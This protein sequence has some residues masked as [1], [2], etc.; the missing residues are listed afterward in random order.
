M[1]R[2]AAYSLPGVPLIHAGEPATGVP[3]TFA[4]VLCAHLRGYDSLAAALPPSQVVMLLEEYFAL[5]TDAVL[6][7]GGQIFHLADADLM[8]GFGLG[9]C[10][11][12]QILEATAAAQAIQ[13]RFAAIRAAWRE[14]WSVEAAVGVGIHRGE[15]A[16]AMYGPATEQ[17]LVIVGD[18]ANLAASLC[19]RARAGEILLSNAV[20]GPL[21]QA[22]G[23]PVR[24]SKE[25]LAL[26][27]V[28]L[29]GRS[30]ALDLWCFP[31][32]ERLTTGA[33][34]RARTHSSE[35]EP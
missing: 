28:R 4:T 29:H 18:T 17:C 5:L 23:R 16:I 12:T 11:H 22:A 7:F 14:R 2:T 6:E 30:A 15:F 31:T 34:L 8:A 25:C 3:T 32:A 24:P 27:Q 33:V 21:E 19:H 9:D 26:S 13:R 20:H 10:R 35:P 1:F